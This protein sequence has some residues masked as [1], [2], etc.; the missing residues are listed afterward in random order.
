MDIELIKKYVRH[1]YPFLMLDRIIGLEKWKKLTAIK[2]ITINEPIFQGHFPELSIFP[3]VMIIEALAQ[4]SGLLVYLSDD[5]PDKACK[6]FY[7]FRSI[8][9][10]KFK[11]PV[12]PGDRLE[13][14]V[15]LIQEKNNYAIFKTKVTALVDD[16]VVCTAE[17]TCAKKGE[18]HE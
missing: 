3:G 13:L 16:L 8:D 14:R 4:A 9:Q 11:K 15:E 2:N 7:Y 6:E 10:A 17:L 18:N 5:N 12:I 1:R